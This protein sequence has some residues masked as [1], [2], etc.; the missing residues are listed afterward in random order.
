MSTIIATTL[1]NG[2]V[3]VPTATVV[4]GSAKA[5]LKVDQRSTQAILGSFNVSSITDVGTGQ[6]TM[7]FSSS[8]LDAGYSI[9][10]GNDFI[11]QSYSQFQSQNAF[12]TSCGVV[13]SPDLSQTIT[14]GIVSAAIHGDLA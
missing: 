4:N 2:S 7:T 13:N 6:T 5:F 10:G 9:S 8:M 1:S 14:D 11:V 3:S 12:T